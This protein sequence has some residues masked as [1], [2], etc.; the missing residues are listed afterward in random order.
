M[1][2]RW[3]TTSNTSLPEAL[4]EFSVAALRGGHGVKGRGCQC[5]VRG[6]WCE[7]ERVSVCGEGDMV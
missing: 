2:Q 6:T 3:W 7:G 5:V 4:R 1:Y